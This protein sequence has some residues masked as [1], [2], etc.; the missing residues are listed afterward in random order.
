L[1]SVVAIM[2]LSADWHDFRAKRDKLHPRYGKPTQL[3]LE[4]A[5]D[6]EADNGK[7]L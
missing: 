5:E 7:G 2:K 6:E 3:A 4:F 1:G